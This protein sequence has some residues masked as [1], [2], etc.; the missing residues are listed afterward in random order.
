MLVPWEY[1]VEEEE[2]LRDE[3]YWQNF[4]LKYIK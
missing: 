2:G 4:L 1:K 3:Q